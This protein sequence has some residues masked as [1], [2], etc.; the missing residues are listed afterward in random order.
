[1]SDRRKSELADKSDELLDAVARLKATEERKRHEPI[2]SDEFHRLANEVDAI[3]HEV[4]AIARDE[5]GVGEKTHRT[6]ETI[7]DVAEQLDKR[8]AVG[9]G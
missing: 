4:F 1:M 2:S 3:S 9:D 6:G 7:E 8:T 5:R